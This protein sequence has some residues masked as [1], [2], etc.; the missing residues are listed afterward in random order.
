MREA[1]L[2]S[3]ADP[4]QF[5]SLQLSNFLQASKLTLQVRCRRASRAVHCRRYGCIGVGALPLT[6]TCLPDAVTVLTDTVWWGVRHSFKPELPQR[7]RWSS[8]SPL[9]WSRTDGTSW[10]TTTLRWVAAS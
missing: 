8:R 6:F 1:L 9:R 2:P 10:W 7:V 3:A 4:E 5:S